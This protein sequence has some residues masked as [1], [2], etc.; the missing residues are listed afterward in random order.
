[1][2]RLVTPPRRGTS[3]TWGRPPPCEQALRFSAID[4]IELDGKL[5]GGGGRGEILYKKDRG[6]RRTFWC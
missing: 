2:E 4:T 5:G 6:G 1:M 3:P